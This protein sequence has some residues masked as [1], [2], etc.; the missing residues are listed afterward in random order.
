MRAWCLQSASREFIIYLCVCRGGMGSGAIELATHALKR[1]RGLFYNYQTYFRRRLKS[2]CRTNLFASSHRVRTIYGC[3]IN[4]YLPTIRAPANE[5]IALKNCPIAVV[6][7]YVV[8]VD[9]VYNR[10]R[11]VHHGPPC[12]CL[13]RLNFFFLWELFPRKE[14]DICAM[15]EYI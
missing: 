14:L 5:R 3:S 10:D 4:Y 15:R 8:P 1:A 13:L 9:I 12:D 11:R 7:R 6:A 2:Q